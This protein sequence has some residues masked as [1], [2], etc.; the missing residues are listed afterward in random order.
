MEILTSKL[1]SRGYG[2]EFP[3]IS[4]SPMT[5]IEVCNYVENVPT[6]QLDKYLFD[7]QKLISEDKRI[8]NCYL[9]DLD[10]L[11]FYKKIC[12]VSEDLSYVITTKCPVCGKELRKTVSLEKDIK[13]KQIDEKIMNGAVIELGGNKYET[14]IP[15]VK[16]FLDVF[17]YFLSFRKITDL[18]LIKTMALIKNFEYQSNQIEEAVL[19]ATHSDVT[20]LMALRDLYYDQVEPIKLLCPNCNKGLKPEERRYVTVSV[21]SL[22]VDFFRDFCINS[23]I[24]GSKI[25][26]K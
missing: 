10:F 8:L 26:F 22:I 16:E 14:R 2:Y 24:S 4:V 15:T 21:D 5:F 9:M 20:L 3:S 18:G 7:I 12:T 13:F 11:I 23:P 25:L 6:D 1:P 17:K 19:G